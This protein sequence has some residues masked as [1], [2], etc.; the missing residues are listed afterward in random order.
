M[1]VRVAR[2]RVVLFALLAALAV[3]GGIAFASIPAAGGTIHGCYQ[4]EN[5]QLRV[6]EK[7]T[8]CRAS[9]L[10]IF[11]N[12]TGPQGLTGATGA[13]GPKGDTGAQGLPG[14]PGAQGPKGDTGLQ[15][16][17]GAQGLKGDTGPQGL[18][19]AQGLKGDTGAQGLKGDAGSQGIQGEAGAQGPQGLR[20]LPARAP[21]PATWSSGSRMHCPALFCR[22]SAQGRPPAATTATR[23]PA[24]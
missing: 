14:T 12:Q 6:V 4:K 23:Q 5:G 19:G 17:P 8:D 1:I 16:L 11:W 10:A 3:T 22:R 21:A 9:E 13:Q 15:G 20:V 18:P 24:T 7:T 2:K